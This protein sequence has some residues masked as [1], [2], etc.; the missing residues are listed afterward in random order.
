MLSPKR[1]VFLHA[2]RFRNGT[3]YFMENQVSDFKWIISHS[4][5]SSRNLLSTKYH[6]D[7]KPCAWDSD[8]GNL[9]WRIGKEHNKSLPT[10]CPELVSFTK[11]LSGDQIFW[12][13]LKALP[14][15]ILGS[16]RLHKETCRGKPLWIQ[17]CKS[18]LFWWLLAGQL[19]K[20]VWIR[21]R[22]FTTLS[23]M[24]SQWQMA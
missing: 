16:L 6:S 3:V 14:W 2:W 24:N 20:Q 11:N 8:D 4:K 5:V 12:V 17:R 1:N 13:D 18:F 7:Y 15:T 22:D 23:K 21:C 19:P 9:Y 10:P